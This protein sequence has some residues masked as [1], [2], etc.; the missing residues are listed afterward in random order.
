MSKRSKRFV[1]LVVGIALMAVQVQAADVSSVQ[2]GDWNDSATWGGSLPTAACDKA[3]VNVGHTV[4]VTAAMGGAPVRL[5]EEGL[6]SSAL[7]GTLN[8]DPSG[9]V[10]WY[11]GSS[12]IYSDVNVNAPT[13]IGSQT[14]SAFI[15]LNDQAI[16]TATAELWSDNADTRIFVNDNAQMIINGTPAA[17]VAI[18]ASAPGVFGGIALNGSGS[19]DMTEGRFWGGTYKRGINLQDGSTT[20]ASVHVKDT[21]F[22]DVVTGGT[23]LINEMLG[24][25]PTP[26]FERSTFDNLSSRTLSGSEVE[27]VDCTL[28]SVTLGDMVIFTGL[29]WGGGWEAVREY[30]ALNYQSDGTGTYEMLVGGATQGALPV[31]YQHGQY[32]PTSDSDV[33]IHPD[34]A[35]YSPKDGHQSSTDGL[36]RLTANG[37]G[38]T[39]TL[40]PGITLDLNGYTLDLED[41][42]ASVTLNGGTIVENGGAII[43]EPATMCLLALGGVSLV[44]RRKRRV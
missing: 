19:L 7:A 13:R 11:G 40:A 33:V 24:A 9:T 1:V 26:L 21:V 30:V 2:T 37:Y 5:R 18:G 42:W 34:L 38:K 10:S 31:S 35:A 6:G 22:Q 28:N 16:L 4:T 23:V 8:V 41:G 12:S 29:G 25:A 27:L 14:G 44:L 43:P 3:V 20:T 17:P 36:V 39:L 32:D 15:S